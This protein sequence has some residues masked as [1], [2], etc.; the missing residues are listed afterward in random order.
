M[1]TD[2]IFKYLYSNRHNSLAKNVMSLV[3]IF[4]AW[5]NEAGR[6]IKPK[7]ERY[8]ELFNK[9]SRLNGY[10]DAGDYWRSQ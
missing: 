6:K 5:R 7:Y 1:V 8:V 10:A 9:K 4:Q 3:Y 2:S